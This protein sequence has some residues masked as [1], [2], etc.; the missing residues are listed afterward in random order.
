MLGLGPGRQLP[1]ARLRR[2]RTMAC[3]R[4]A[5]LIGLLRL[6]MATGL[7]IASVTIAFWAT[8]CPWF[9]AY[10]CRLLNAT[11]G[12][13]GMLVLVVTCIVFAPKLPILNDRS[14]AVL[15]NIFMTLFWCS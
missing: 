4:V 8:L 5:V 14:T 15:G 9:P 11:T 6:A 3:R 1:T 7:L 13:T 2:F 10:S 12:M